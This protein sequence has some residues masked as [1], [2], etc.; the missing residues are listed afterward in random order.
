MHVHLCVCL[1]MHVVEYIYSF[2]INWISQ[3]QQ[4]QK[5]GLYMIQVRLRFREAISEGSKFSA[6]LA[7]ADVQ[8]CCKTFL[9]HVSNFLS[10]SGQQQKLSIHYA[11][12]GSKQGFL[13]LF[14]ENIMLKQNIILKQNISQSGMK[15]LL[16]S[17]I[18]LM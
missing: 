12:N 13:T 11:I 15:L 16:D 10:H 7:L 2:H 3:A 9:G 17:L 4:L 6:F 8:S 1:Y 18:C 14:L 5:Y